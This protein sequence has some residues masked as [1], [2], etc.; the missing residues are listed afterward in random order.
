LA[1]TIRVTVACP[2]NA[3]VPSWLFCRAKYGIVAPLGS[4]PMTMGSRSR[5]SSQTLDP[6]FRLPPVSNMTLPSSSPSIT[7]AMSYISLLLTVTKLSRLTPI[8]LL[9]SL[10]ALA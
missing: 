6:P 4:P 10:R 3:P 7:S 5:S 8:T 2:R 9:V 1:Q